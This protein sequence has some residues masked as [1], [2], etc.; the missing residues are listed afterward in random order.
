LIWLRASL[1]IAILVPVELAVVHLWIAE[2]GLNFCCFD[3]TDS[4]DRPL[5]L[6]LDQLPE[7]SQCCA[8]LLLAFKSIVSDRCIFG[9]YVRLESSCLLCA[10]DLIRL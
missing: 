5:T 2:Q 4:I 10:N 7:G 8:R 3:I 1:S 9:C 6:L